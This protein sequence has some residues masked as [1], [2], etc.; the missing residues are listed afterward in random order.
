MTKAN[1][2]EDI[3]KSTAKGTTGVFFA[4]AIG[5]II[6][7]FAM[8]VLARLLGPSEFGLIAVIMILPSIAM[9]FQDWAVSHAITR[10]V[11]AFRAKNDVMGVR[12]IIVVGATFEIISGIT[13]SLISFALADY[14]SITILGYPELASLIRVASWS[15]LG[16]GMFLASKSILVGLY[17]M[18]QFGSLLLLAPLFQGVL[19]ATLVIMGGGLSGAI[20]GR[21]IGSILIGFG[22]IL[23]V[24]YKFGSITKSL[25]PKETP[26]FSTLRLMFGYGLLIY[27][28]TIIGGALPQILYTIAAQQ[29]GP[30]ILGNYVAAI[31][32]SGLMLF[33]SEPIMTVIFPAF[34]ML[35]RSVQQSELKT[36]Y[37]LG[38]K[39]TSFVVLLAASMLIVSS[40]PLVWILF[41][42]GYELASSL[43]VLS[44][45]VYFLAPFG[46]VIVGSFLRG[47]N[48]TKVYLGM[49]IG[50]LFIGSLLGVL[51]APIIGAFGLILANIIGYFVAIVLGT[52][53]IDWKFGYRVQVVSSL[54]LFFSTAI[55]TFLGI[56]VF[57][58][59][60][61]S[62]MIIALVTAVCV[63]ILA[64][65]T[66]F[67]L[68]RPFDKA[69]F[70]NARL[71]VTSMGR[72][73][74]PLFLLLDVLEKVSRIVKSDIEFSNNP[75][76]E[77]HQITSDL[78]PETVRSL[79]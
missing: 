54:K 21:V 63:L 48:E 6:S 14:F 66:S 10:H 40:E 64:E 3:A 41:G 35:D 43:M 57:N 8:V 25:G 31:S 58:T 50:I 36:L 18:S 79:L 75:E 68:F 17:E 7:I 61:N 29:L 2:L 13:L 34:S 33:I 69:D 70:E 37:V 27:I 44:V 30:A 65:I 26:W 11:S 78:I 28:S 45:S 32:L 62:G 20:F 56:I 53:W 5:G 71:L 67:G 1:S 39:Y 74:I 12:N 4:Q 76:Y 73:G 77:R 55:A 46:S 19:P 49:H 38:T 16:M 24:A 9:L 42:T 52:G 23:T 51:L 47:Q 59:L 15:V 60:R 72:I 22:G